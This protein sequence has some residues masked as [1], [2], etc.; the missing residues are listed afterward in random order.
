MAKAVKE[1]GKA[2]PHPPEDQLSVADFLK[3]LFGRRENR[4]VVVP[5]LSSDSNA[6]FTRQTNELHSCRLPGGIG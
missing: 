2:K 6:S 4:S 3:T 5:L 1:R